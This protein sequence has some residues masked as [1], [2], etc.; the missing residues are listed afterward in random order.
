MATEIAKILTVF[1]EM[2][3]DTPTFKVL[4][5]ASDLDFLIEVP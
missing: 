2:S 3:F 4:V 5:S 1:F